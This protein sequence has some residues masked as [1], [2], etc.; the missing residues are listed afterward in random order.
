MLNIIFSNPFV[1]F[2]FGSILL[3]Y[4]S[5]LLISNSIALSEKFN[6]PRFI[7]GGT[8]IALG[9]SLPEIIVSIS[10]NIKGNSDVAI[11]NIV[12]SN[13]A[14]LGLILGISLCFK[15]F[16][17]NKSNNE[18]L[19]NIVSLLF[20]TVVFYINLLN[21]HFLFVHGCMFLV[22]YCLY[23]F[24]YIKYFKNEDKL[25]DIDNNNSFN[26]IKLILGVILIYYGSQFFIDG[27]LGIAHKIGM[28]DIAVG[29]TIIALGTSAPELIVSLNAIKKNESML[30]IGNIFGSNI[31]NIVFAGGIA[32]LIKNIYISHNEIFIFSSIM[33]FLTIL[34]SLIM[35]FSKKIYKIYSLIFTSVYIIF[36][37]MNFSN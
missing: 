12:G 14:N 1:I 26:I 27:A 21:G 30:V 13:I 37:Y 17:I 9:T 28:N 16:N 5:E 35:L 34:L 32:S 36:I 23:F 8:I 11:G 19:F 6:V 25:D 20:I 18:Y 10:A 24:I 3:Y 29:L 33:L 31:A 7:I 4:S 2:M 22:F 15:S